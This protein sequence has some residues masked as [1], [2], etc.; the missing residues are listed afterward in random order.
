MGYQRVNT[1][2]EITISSMDEIYQIIQNYKAFHKLPRFEQ[3]EDSPAL[4][5]FYRG[6]S[7]CEWDIS[8]SLSRS[9]RSEQ[10]SISTFK[11]DKNMS[12]FETIA[13]IQHHCQGTRFID[14]TKNPD[15]AIYFACSGSDDKNGALYIYDYAPHE[16]E[17][18]TTTILGGMFITGNPI[19]TLES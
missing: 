10:T 11:H 14:F 16:P 9:E 8:P 2:Q 18:Y 13:Y 6:Q 3:G 15:V 1:Y 5:C 7:N 19:I 4:D 12:L 17:W